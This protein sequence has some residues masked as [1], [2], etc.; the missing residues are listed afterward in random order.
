MLAIVLTINKTT[1]EAARA[2]PPGRMGDEARRRKERV[3]VERNKIQ[4][5]ITNNTNYQGIKTIEA[6]FIISTEDRAGYL[7]W[8]LFRCH[9]VG[10]NRL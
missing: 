10:D 2:A 4:Q 9:G 5:F 7:F 6:F 8:C 3:L 1:A